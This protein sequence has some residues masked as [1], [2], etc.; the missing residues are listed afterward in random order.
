[1]VVS[2][3]DLIIISLLSQSLILATVFSVLTVL[4]PTFYWYRHFKNHGSE[5][6]HNG[7]PFS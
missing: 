4:I 1:M 2:G 6:P 5:N 7:E 3:I